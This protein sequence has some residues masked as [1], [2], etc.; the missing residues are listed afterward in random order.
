MRRI[1]LDRA[2][3]G[4]GGSFQIFNDA[5]TLPLTVHS[6]VP[7]VDAPWISINPPP[8]Y[9]IPPR[10]SRIIHV[11][12]NYNLA[13]EGL[14]SLRLLLNSND[15]H[16]NPYPGGFYLNANAIP[17]SA[18]YVSVPPA[19]HLLALPATLVGESSNAQEIMVHN[20]GDGLLEIS[21]SLVGDNADEFYFDECNGVVAPGPGFSG[22]IRVFCAP[23]SVGPKQAILSLLTNAVENTEI[24]YPLT[25]VGI[26]ELPGEPIKADSYEGGG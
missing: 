10:S 17:P 26:T 25:C 20:P 14:S 19:G 7:A 8:P 16:E 12:V 6:I 15:P 5:P 11:S 13:H 18:G 3:V 2:L 1:N 24:Q 23:D 22:L 4:F 21:C 9:V